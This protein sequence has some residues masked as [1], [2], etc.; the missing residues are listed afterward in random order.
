M[1][2]LEPQFLNMEPTTIMPALDQLA[3]Q[4]GAWAL[5]VILLGV[6]GYLFRHIIRENAAQRA[7]DRKT[8]DR[9]ATIVANNT[10]GFQILSEIVRGRKD[11]P[12]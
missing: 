11:K 5:V 6:I 10:A 1:E 12:E 8:I 7:E 4:G 9:L 3:S 2:D